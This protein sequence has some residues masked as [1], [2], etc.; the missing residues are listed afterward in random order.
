MTL[1]P[2]SSIGH[3]H[4]KE[5]G[6]WKSYMKYEDFFIYE[7][8]KLEYGI[9]AKY[10]HDYATSIWF[11][12]SNEF[13]LFPQKYSVMSGGWY[14]NEK[15]G[16]WRTQKRTFGTVNFEG[17]T[18]FVKGVKSEKMEFLINKPRMTNRFQIIIANSEIE[19]LSFKC[20]NI[21][22]KPS[23]KILLFDKAKNKFVDMT[24]QLA[25]GG[26]SFKE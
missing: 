19:T 25:E 3:I 17:I 9:M 1:V 22:F 20:D 21:N 5:I 10:I 8:E 12:D 2:Q 11:K 16:R 7:Y 14:D 6:Y 15:G 18:D 24:E 26:L 4:A 13:E 23:D